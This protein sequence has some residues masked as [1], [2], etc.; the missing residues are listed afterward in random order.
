[1]ALS[2]PRAPAR[3][4]RIFSGDLTPGFFCRRLGWDRRA[5]AE[6]NFVKH[7]LDF[8]H[9]QWRHEATAASD[10]LADHRALALVR[11]NPAA[12]LGEKFL[13]DLE[14]SVRHPDRLEG[15]RSMLNL[16]LKRTHFSEN[17][18]ELRDVAADTWINGMPS[19]F[20]YFVGR[21]LTNRIWGES[22]G[23]RT[24]RYNVDVSECR[25]LINRSKHHR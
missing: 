22:A 3:P 19:G 6:L 14:L 7:D 10:L 12:C 17:P 2:A 20:W 21:P 8:R 1:M 24:W 9:G 16:R 5:A 13:T 18:V 4:A 11:A 23:S 15:T 25:L